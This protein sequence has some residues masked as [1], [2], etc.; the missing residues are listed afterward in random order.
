MSL[1][2]LIQ[3]VSDEFKQAILNGVNR[4]IVT[5]KQMLLRTG[6]T[7]NKIYFIEKGL[8]RGY[9]IKDGKDV[10]SWFMKEGDIIISIIS[11]YL[12]QPSHEYIEMIEGGIVW[13]LTYEKLQS[14]YTLFPEFNYSG[15]LITEK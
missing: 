6:D 2:S 14:L 7:N 4:E 9:Y 1:L 10:T 11:F 3:P 13:S 12:R 8:A 15:R 5:K